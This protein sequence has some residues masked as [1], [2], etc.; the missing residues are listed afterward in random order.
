RVLL[1]GKDRTSFDAVLNSVPAELTGNPTATLPWRKLRSCLLA[2]QS[3]SQSEGVFSVGSNFDAVQVW[4][5]PLSNEFIE[6]VAMAADRLN[7]L[8]T[9]A[10][11]PGK[12]LAGVVDEIQ[13]LHDASLVD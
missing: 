5:P 3:L 10:A 6:L 4:L 9:G 7:E 8:R 13:A 2:N 12:K 1:T 11:T